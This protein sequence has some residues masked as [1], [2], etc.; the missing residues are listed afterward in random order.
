MATKE[1]MVSPIVIGTLVCKSFTDKFPKFNVYNI[2]ISCKETMC[3]VYRPISKN[4]VT[5]GTFQ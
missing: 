2:P 3:D 5:A 4:V 1:G